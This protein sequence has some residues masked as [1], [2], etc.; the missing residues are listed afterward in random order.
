MLIFLLSLKK[1]QV[2]QVTAIHK[3]TLRLIQS[4]VLQNQNNLLHYPL[5]KF[6][7][8]FKH[9]D[10]QRRFGVLMAV[11]ARITVFLDLTL[12]SLAE[13]YQSALTEHIPTEHSKCST[14]LQ[15]TEIY[16]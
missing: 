14:R 6:N 5:Y 13:D 1:S 10:N 8:N 11:T 2:L 7:L 12:C 9:R 3:Y 15:K 16:I 4:S